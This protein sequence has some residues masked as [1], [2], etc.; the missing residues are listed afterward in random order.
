[1]IYLNDLDPLFK[2]AAII[3]VRTQ[4]A[5]TSLIQRSL[6]IGYNRAGKIIDQLE[7]IGIV[8]GFYGLQARKT[9]IPDEKSLELFF[10]QKLNMHNDAFQLSNDYY[11]LLQD[12]SL[13]VNRINNRLVSNKGIQQKFGF[14]ELDAKSYISYLMVYELCQLL[15]KITDENVS[16]TTLEAI[17]FF[18]ITKQ[19]IST[20]NKDFLNDEYSSIINSL[21]REEFRNAVE[22]ILKTGKSEAIKIEISSAKSEL[23]WNDHLTKKLP[24]LLALKHQNDD[25]F[26]EYCQFLYH[27]SNIIIKADGKISNNEEILLNEIYKAIHNP[28]PQTTNQAKVSS[29]ASDSLDDVL[30]E[31]NSLIGLDDVKLEISTL[32]NFIKIQKAREQ[33][34]LKSS[35]LSYHII[36]T[37]NPG[38]GKTTVARIVAKIYKHLGI[39]SDGQLVETDRSGLIAEYVGQTAVKVNRT[40]DSAMN[41]VLFI[42]EAYSLVGENKDDFGKEAVATLIKRMEDDRDKLVLVLAGY[43]KE[44]EKFIDTNPGFKSRFNRHINFQDYTP[45]ELFEIFESQCK[46][47]EYE[48]AENAKIKLKVF[49]ENSYLTRD[50]SFGNGRFVRNIFEKTLEKQANRIAKENIL[51]KEILTTITVEDIIE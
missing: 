32:I 2:D 35:A 14:S 13:D 43:T 18:L 45:K 44:M 31:L 9:L 8:G 25:F 23:E 41:G 48:L 38:T 46:T 17:A 6:K 3:I 29:N 39:L 15:Y 50:R 11:K 47:L 22:S 37:G 36:F 34:G 5:S 33:A 26:E 40:V 51:T 7:E 49:F 10:S 24:I 16:A 4:Q 28:L 21:G 27:F 1:M 12:F 30:E 19:L 20:Q 42:D